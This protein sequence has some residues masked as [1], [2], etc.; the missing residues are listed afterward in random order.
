LTLLFVKHA[1]VPVGAQ[2]QA[3]IQAPDCLPAAMANWNWTYNSLNQAPCKTAA[4]LAAPCHDGQFTIQ[5]IPEKGHCD[6]PTKSDAGDICRCNSV[7]YSLISACVGCQKGV[8][9]SYEQWHANCTNVS[10]MSTFPQGINNDTSVPAWAFVNVS[11]TIP[12]DNVTACT[13]GDNPESTGTSR[14]P[15]APQFDEGH[16]VRVAVIVGVTVG[17]GIVVLVIFG[18]GA[19]FLL[20]R[21]QRRRQQDTAERGSDRYV[22]TPWKPDS[23]DHSVTEHS[24]QHLGPYSRRYSGLPEI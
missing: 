16:F 11:E 10:P 22:I 12:W 1:V 14:P 3:Q 18:T 23:P 7:Y 15:F 8:W 5:Q 13:V 6:G 9:I 20:R 4:Y 21:R 24:G 19:W 17:C 2:A